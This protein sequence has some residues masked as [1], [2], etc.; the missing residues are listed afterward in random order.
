MIV[1]S[2]LLTRE[3]M[4]VRVIYTGNP[5]VLVEALTDLRWSI[6]PRIRDDREVGSMGLISSQR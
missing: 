6:K 3:E 4:V 2:I 1:F 5:R